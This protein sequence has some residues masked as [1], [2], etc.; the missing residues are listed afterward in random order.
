MTD[1]A[2]RF[3]REAVYHYRNASG[4]TLYRKVKRRCGECGA[5]TFANQRRLGNH[6]TYV[7]GL[8]DVEKVPYNLPCVVDAVAEGTP[9]W[10]VEGE[11]DV[12]TLRELGEVATCSPDGGGSWSDAMARHLYGAREVRIVGDADTVGRKY[13]G[14]IRRT[15]AGHVDH[16][17]RFEAGTD[18]SALIAAGGTLSDLVSESGDTYVSRGI[19]SGLAPQFARAAARKDDPRLSGGHYRVPESWARLTHQANAATRARMLSA[20]YAREGTPVAPDAVPLRCGG[21]EGYVMVETKPG[22]GR[23]CHRCRIT[24]ETTGG[25]H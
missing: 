25:R 18:V 3:K 22:K 7:N 15:L 24:Y 19:A 6:E 9:I 1:H 14:E 2:H 21:C 11:K 5:K 23:V 4:V 10:I 13:A 20:P 17:A 12:E 8:G 16:I